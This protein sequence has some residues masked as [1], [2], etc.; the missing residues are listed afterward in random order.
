M[1]LG[2]IVDAATDGLQA[3]EAFQKTKYHLILMD[4]HMPVCNGLDATKRIREIEKDTGGHIP[5]IAVTA[6]VAD[7]KVCEEAGMD[8]SVT[9]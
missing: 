1:L 2:Y 4:V 8:G 6:S 3:I 7:E 5:I 9:I